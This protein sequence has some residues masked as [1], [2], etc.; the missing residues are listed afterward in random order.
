[1]L[2]HSKIKKHT[3]KFKKSKRVK[4]NKVKIKLSTPEMVGDFI[5]VCSKYDCDINLYE[6]RN[7]V[8]AKSIV[9][10]FSIQFEKELEVEIISNDK[11][12]LSDFVSNIK[13]FEVK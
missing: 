4:L 3:C 1:M 9:A 8:D 2:A 13:K 6:G 11:N 5:N 10:V 12:I 7:I